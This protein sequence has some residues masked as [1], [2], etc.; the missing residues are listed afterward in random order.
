MPYI[1]N[2][3]SKLEGK[4]RAG[5]GDCVDLVKTYVPGLRSFS[6]RSCWR[7]GERVVDARGLAKGTAIATFVKGR[8]P[9]GSSGQHAAIFLS[10]AGPNSF[11]VM[12]QWLDKR[13]I[14]ARLI[15]P[16]KPSVKQMPDGSWPDASNVGPAFSVIELSCA[17]K[18]K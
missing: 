14:K 8:Y 12:D 18:G 4:A 3:V 5:E 7:P 15:Y 16:P 17:A 13:K 2:D 9:S 11:W 10:H 6:A 1:Y